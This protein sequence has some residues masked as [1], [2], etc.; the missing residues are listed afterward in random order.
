MI[1][2]GRVLHMFISPLKNA[3]LSKIRYIYTIL[4]VCILGH[5]L[6]IDILCFSVAKTADSSQRT[7][8]I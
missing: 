8:L 7:N 3:S 2:V 4:I 1:V 6:S 5:I